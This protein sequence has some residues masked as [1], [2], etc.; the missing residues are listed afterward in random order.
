MYRILATF[1]I[2]LASI[3]LSPPN[4]EA[5]ISVELRDTSIARGSLN[6]IPVYGDIPDSGGDLQITVRF[7]AYVIDIKRIITDA[8]TGLIAHGFSVELKDLESSLLVVSSDNYKTP[9]SDVLFYMEVEGLAG[10]DTST[11]VVPLSI[12]IGGVEQ[13]G[14]VLDSGTISVQSI[15][16][17]PKLT[18]GL[19]L[20]FPNPFNLYTE[21]FFSVDSDSK[22]SFKIF[23]LN[24]RNVF[25]PE[26]NE[27]SFVT[28]IY[29]DS[30]NEIANYLEH[31]FAAGRYRMRLTPAS[32][33][34]SAG[35]Y[36]LVMAV[37][38]QVYKT[39]FIYYK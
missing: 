28:E 10:P 11:M 24:G 37:Q 32:W 21:I 39:N 34:I 33:Q 25:S 19:G 22:V 8:S 6:V 15:P 2:I 36:Y 13:E 23:S 3:I 26:I 12:K 4:S 31:T 27:N 29:D 20:N 17:R 14:A 9:P 30:G 7:N 5:Q 38:D 35:A 16:V 18:E 1:L